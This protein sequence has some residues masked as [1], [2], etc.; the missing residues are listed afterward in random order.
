VAYVLTSA[1]CSRGSR[2]LRA[3]TATTALR[4]IQD[5]AQS[6]LP[7]LGYSVPFAIGA[8]LLAACR[9]VIVLLTQ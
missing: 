7:V 4:A 5:Q 8:V 3:G 2:R 1:P 6:K 9:P